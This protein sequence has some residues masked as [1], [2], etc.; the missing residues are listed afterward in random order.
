MVAICHQ[1]TLPGPCRHDRESRSPCSPQRWAPGLRRRPRG[2]TP[3]V[4]RLRLSATARTGIRPG[5]SS[6]TAGLPTYQSAAARRSWPTDRAL[7]VTRC[8]SQASWSP[9]VR[10]TF[11]PNAPRAFKVGIPTQKSGSTAAHPFTWRR[12]SRRRAFRLSHRSRTRRSA[13]R[14]RKSRTTP[15]CAPAFF[16]ED[17]RC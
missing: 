6:V 16:S 3:P 9:G 4:I 15:A 11:P 5:T 14:P 13:S 12:L 10:R 2:S 7:R 17:Q 8:H 1:W